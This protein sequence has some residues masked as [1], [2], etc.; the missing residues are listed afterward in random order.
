[1]ND[2]NLKNLKEELMKEGALEKEAEDLTL[3]SKNLSNLYSFER[4]SALKHKF[5]EQELLPKNKFFVSRQMFAAVF[6]SLILLLGFTSIIKA[7]S[8]LPGQ[9]LYPVKIAS[10]NIAS[11]INPSFKD[12]VLQRRSEE[13]KQLSGK[14]DGESFQNLV[15]EYERELDENRK[16]NSKKIDEAQKNL[17]E[18][19]KNSLDEHKEDIERAIIKT[20]N[21]QD[22]EEKE[23]EEDRL[24]SRESNIKSE[25]EDNR[26]F[27]GRPGF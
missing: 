20:E 22:E 18:A 17:E 14:K 9:P 19:R 1:M 26:S 27:E 2:L 24:N 3:L 10:E 16:I 6:L 4:S 13:I 5:L 21:R 12:E 23:D 15:N 7:Q 25:D 8:S 11:L